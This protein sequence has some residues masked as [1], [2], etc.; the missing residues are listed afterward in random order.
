MRGSS[1][2][3]TRSRGADCALRSSTQPAKGTG[4]HVL[5]GSLLHLLLLVC[6]F[7]EPLV[8]VFADLL[9]EVLVV[10]DVEVAVHVDHHLALGH[11]LANVLVAELQAGLLCGVEAE[12]LHEHAACGAAGF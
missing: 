10:L 3:S 5:H 1:L 12:R 4:L 11:A 9:V 8:A 6:H 7:L 2:G